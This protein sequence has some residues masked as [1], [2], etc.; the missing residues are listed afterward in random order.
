MV[1]KYEQGK[2]LPSIETIILIG[3]RLD[4]PLDTL[5]GLENP[6]KTGKKKRKK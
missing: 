4:V 5:L 2:S 1:L 6:K 3:K